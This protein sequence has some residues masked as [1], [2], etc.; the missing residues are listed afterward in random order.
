ML[1]TIKF[2]F[3]L[4]ICSIL[5][6][7][8]TKHEKSIGTVLED[9]RGQI[10]QTNEMDSQMR[11]T[12]QWYHAKRG[13]WPNNWESLTSFLDENKIPYDSSSIREVQ[14]DQTEDGSIRCNYELV[15]GATST[16]IIQ[17]PRER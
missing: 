4:L 2:S 9:L 5:A 3:I 7:C 16:L 13:V 17:I 1:N 10:A 6:G 14:L 12:L 15:S 11:L 8:V